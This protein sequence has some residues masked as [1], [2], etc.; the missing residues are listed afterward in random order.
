MPR[1][2]S[3]PPPPQMPSYIYKASWF[4]SKITNMGEQSMDQCGAHNMSKSY[5]FTKKF[6]RFEWKSRC[7]KGLFKQGI[8]VSMKQPLRAICALETTSRKANAS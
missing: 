2:T 5:M 8:R 1:L 6:Q 3:T 4:F 7:T